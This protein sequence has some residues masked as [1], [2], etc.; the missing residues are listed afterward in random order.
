MV[1]E[2][3]K[4]TEKVKYYLKTFFIV[5]LVLELK[6]YTYIISKMLLTLQQRTEIILI[7]RQCF[8]RDFRIIILYIIN[9][10]ELIKLVPL[11]TKRIDQPSTENW[12]PH[13]VLRNIM[14]SPENL[15]LWNNDEF[16]KCQSKYFDLLMR[17]CFFFNLPWAWWSF[18]SPLNFKCLYLLQ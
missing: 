11:F 14:E 4:Q 13:F 5:N 18:K 17:G 15:I 8:M 9:V 1:I 10:I 7:Y 12:L 2:A 3:W 6:E 16:D